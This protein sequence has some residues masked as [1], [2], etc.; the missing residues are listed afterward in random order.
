MATLP[1]SPFSSVDTGVSAETL[2][3]A[4]VSQAPV[5]AAS[6]HPSDSGAALACSPENAA[7][8]VPQMPSAGAAAD[9][10]DDLK[11]RL[12]EAIEDDYRFVLDEE[13]FLFDIGCVPSDFDK[14]IAMLDALAVNDEPPLFLQQKR[15]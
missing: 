5:A 14:Y 12:L 7:A 1:P 13:K 2:V 4:S 9:L 11:Q 6:S 10:P 8:P 3:V 15:A